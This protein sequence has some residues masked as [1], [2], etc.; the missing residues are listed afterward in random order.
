MGHPTAC[1]AG[2]AVQRTIEND[3]LLS[4]V[5]TQGALL[6]E[7][8]QERF[9]RHRHIGDIRGRG[10]FLGLEI[11][12]DRASKAPMP[13]ADRIHTAIKREAMNQG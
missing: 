12:A 9:G 8:L 10:L 6:M 13:A 4:N 3:D 7:A 11:V 2:L 5:N 1:A